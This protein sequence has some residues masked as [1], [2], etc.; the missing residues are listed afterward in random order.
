M[1][2][3]MKVTIPVEAGNK[4]IKDGSLPKTIMAFVEQWKPEACYFVAE[5][6]H[7]VGHLYFDM[8]N[9]NDLPSVAEPFF[10]NLN[11]AIQVSPAMN[12]DDLKVGVEK[13]MKKA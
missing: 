5:N 8:K 7:R 3:L 6:G 11:A 4:A 2:M 13:A 1:R 12:L 10:L 9:S